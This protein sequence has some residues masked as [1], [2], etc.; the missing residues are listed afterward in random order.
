MANNLLSNP[1][2]LDT[3]G[4]TSRIQRPLTVVG[5]IVNAGADTWQAVIH[6][7]ETGGTIIFQATSDITNHRSIYWAPTELFT[8]TGLFWTTDTDIDN[9]LIYLK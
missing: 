4:A 8:F 1:I 9:I 7:K 2:F 6:D 3:A 5:I